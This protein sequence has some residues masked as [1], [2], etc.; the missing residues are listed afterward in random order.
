MVCC[1]DSCP[2]YPQPRQLMRAARA[3]ILN[4]KREFPVWPINAGPAKFVP[5]RRGTFL[6]PAL[7]RLLGLHS[8]LCHCPRIASSEGDVFMSLSAN[9]AP[10]LPFL[11]RFSRAVSGSQESGDALVAA[12]LEAIIAD[13]SIFPEAPTSASR[14]TRFSP[15]CSPRSPSACRRSSRSSAW[16]QRAAANLSACAAPAPGLPAGRRRRLQR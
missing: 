10:H 7:V 1:L 13:I 16:E 12:M 6:E 5:S 14:S 8:E 4:G 15:S 9:I 3:D 11:R 2:Y